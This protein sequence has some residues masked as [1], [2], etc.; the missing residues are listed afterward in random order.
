MEFPKQEYQRGLPFLPPG[1]LPDLGIEPTSPALAGGFFTTE[2]PGKP[3]FLHS[4][5]LFCKSIV[6]AVHFA[7]NRSFPL[8]VSTVDY[9]YPDW[10]LHGFW[11]SQ[12][13]IFC[14]MGEFLAVNL[15][16]S[17]QMVAQ[18]YGR[19]NPHLESVKIFNFVFFPN[20][21]ALINSVSSVIWANIWSGRA[22]AFMTSSRLA[23]AYAACWVPI[24]TKLPSVKHSTS[25]LSRGSSRRSDPRE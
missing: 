8:M 24:S 11:N 15:P 3:R 20:C 13:L 22:L 25:G 4:S 6:F 5:C 9:C 7:D 2:P 10:E 12:N 21:K 17:L 1:Y 23:V 18:A 16:L 14:F 19:W